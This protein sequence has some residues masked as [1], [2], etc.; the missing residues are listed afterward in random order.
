MTKGEF[1][2]YMK[3]Q[4]FAVLG[5]VM[6]QSLYQ[7]ITNGSLLPGDKLYEVQIAKN[8]GISRSPVKMAIS[9]LLQEGMLEKEDGKVPRVK[10]ITY[11]ECLSLYEARITLEGM[12]A[13]HAAKRISKNE[14]DELKS[15][16]NRFV[17]ID[18]SLDGMEFA[19]CD[20]MFHTII[21]NASRNKYI[22]EMYDYLKC[23]L[24]RYRYHFMHL[25]YEKYFE[26]NDLERNSYYHKA[27]YH[28]LVNR[29]SLLAKNEIEEDI[30]RMYGTI[31]SIK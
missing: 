1:D 31:H 27:I 23:G 26:D 9:R 14:L 12:A 30:G 22:I 7:E 5:E 19:R 3:E 8:L 29:L 2:N 21:V 18:A 10:H 25:T 15:L 6:Y 28:A 4:P 11:D 16:V 24:Q 20:E 17:A 13:Y